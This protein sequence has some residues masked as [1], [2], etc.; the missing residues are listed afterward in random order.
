MISYTQLIV[1]IKFICQFGFFPWNVTSTTIKLANSPKFL[2]GILGIRK[3]EFYAFW[4]IVLL[5][6]LFFHRYMLRK[7]GLW[8]NASSVPDTFFEQVSIESSTAIKDSEQDEN[9]AQ[10]GQVAIVNN[11]GTGNGMG[12]EGEVKEGGASKKRGF[13]SELFYRLFHPKYRY[14]RDLYPFMFLVDVLCFFVVSFGY[15]S[16][17]Y[18]GSGSVVKDISSNRV[19][20]T[21]VVM[22]IVISVMIVIDRAL[23]LRKAVLC[24]LIYQFITIIF[25]HVWIFFVLPTITYQ[26]AWLNKTAQFLY[27]VKC[28]YLLISAWQI[29]NGY[30]S[31]CI[32]N[33]ITHAYGLANMVFFKAFM[34]IP[35]LFEVRTAID[36]T[37]IDTSMPLFDF[38]NMENFYATIYNL[39]CAR[40]FEQN[41]PAPRGVAKGV[42]VKYL[43]GIPMILILILVI[44]LPLLAFSL[45]NRIGL[46]LIPDN[47]QMTISVEGYP[48]L[49]SMEAQGIELVMLNE[50]EYLHIQNAFAE[51]F[52]SSNQ[53]SILRARQAVAFINEYTVEDMLVRF[54]IIYD[55]FDKPN[56][57]IILSI[58]S[59]YSTLEKIFVR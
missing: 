49:Y 9:G 59:I 37:W 30:P 52:N 22:L 56:S 44:W 10:R 16:F 25:L 12:T 41:F 6:A 5:V 29:R 48:P 8:D 31:L 3:E 50:S 23:Y 1:I 4:D 20:I 2:P 34:A 46:S 27:F 54:C 36:W 47:V 15:S 35:F 19:P 39:K 28:V 7:M 57:N 33:L 13:L 14:I 24:K 18:G 26:A 40:T 43:M 51:R 55:Y 45:L 38:F 58:C 21:F 11:S 53:N 42:V 32:G 17:G